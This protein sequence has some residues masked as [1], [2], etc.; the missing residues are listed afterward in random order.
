MKNEPSKIGNNFLN[1]LLLV[2]LTS[3]NSVDFINSQYCLAACL[4]MRM[5]YH[6]SKPVIGCG[7]KTA[8]CACRHTAFNDTLKSCDIVQDELNSLRQHRKWANVW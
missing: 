5:Y 8:W 4:Y 7:H 3:N 6:T 2:P 1:I